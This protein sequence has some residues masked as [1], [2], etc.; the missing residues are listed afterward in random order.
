MTTESFRKEISARLAALSENP[1]ETCTEPY[2]FILHF[3][4]GIL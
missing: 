3:I 2:V 1:D 4:V